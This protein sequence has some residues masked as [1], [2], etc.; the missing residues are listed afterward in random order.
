MNGA[1]GG[2]GK[3]A[4]LQQETATALQPSD[5]SSIVITNNFTF[6]V[7][8]KIK[9]CDS[10][11]LHNT[12]VLEDDPSARCSSNFHPVQTFCATHFSACRRTTFLKTAPEAA[13]KDVNVNRFFGGTAYLSLALRLFHPHHLECGASRSLPGANLTETELKQIIWD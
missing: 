4:P 6:M 11:V 2:W 12:F 5:S 9:P 13:R 1:G 8:E 3:Q 7:N 10:P